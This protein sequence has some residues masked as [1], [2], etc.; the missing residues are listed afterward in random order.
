LFQRHARVADPTARRRGGAGLGLA[1]SH[2]LARLMG[3]DLKARSAPGAGSSFSLRSPMLPAQAPASAP[4][5]A[6]A[7]LARSLRVLVAEDHPVNRM[8]L[9]ALLERLG[10]QAHQAEH[11]RQ[12]LEAVQEQSYDLV[13]MDVHMPVMDGVEAT[14]AIRA[15]PA[16]TQP[17]IVALTAD[18]FADTRKRCLDAGI[19][20]VATKPM[21]AASLSALLHRHFALAGPLPQDPKSP[22]TQGAA[23]TL[24]LLDPS[25]QAD[26]RQTVGEQHCRAMYTG[27]FEQ[28]DHTTQRMR[29]AMRQAD[30]ESLRR[31]AHAVKGASLNLGLPALADAAATL[32]AEA[33]AMAAP[34]LA[35]AVQRFDEMVR[36]TRSLCAAE[37]LIGE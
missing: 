7:A 3:G 1:I 17:R 26:V 21:S 20:E 2:R 24:Q 12:A 11:G 22:P 10:H 9:G 13:L 25:A 6:G 31:L 27:L 29:E 18:V 23:S 16:V 35:L 36:A 4:T 5:A 32:S 8:Y 33:H 28:A 34:Q 19:D 15:L 30:V 37:G 14:A